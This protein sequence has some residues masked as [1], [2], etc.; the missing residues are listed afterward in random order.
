MVVQ[1]IFNGLVQASVILLGALGLNLLYGV[2]KFANFAHGDLMTLGAYFTLFFLP[3]VAGSYSEAALGAVLVLA[4]VGLLQ[5]FLIYA[6]LEP[7]GPIP[8][9]VASIGVSL[10]LQNSISASFGPGFKS[11]PV[12]YPDNWLFLGGAISANPLQDVLPLV[13]GSVSCVLLLLLLR[14]TKLGTAMRATA[15]NRELARVSGVNVRSVNWSTWILACVLAA[16]GGTVTGIRTSVLSPDLGA[17]LLLAMFA[18]VIVGGI[19]STWGAI[20]G[21]LVVGVSQSLFFAVSLLTGVDPRWQIAVP[22]AILVLVLLVRPTGLVGKAVGVE[23]RSLRVEI[24][25]M[26]KGLRRGVANWRT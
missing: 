10:V 22:F 13:V 19:G 17:G 3:R 9:L 20:L 26:L 14:Y 11:F 23:T 4:G 16:L 8:P 18:A 15:D 21:S 5:E 7:R 25:E 1:F 12:R 6:P 2:K 24:T